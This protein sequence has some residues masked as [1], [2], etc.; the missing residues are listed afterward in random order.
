[1][2]APQDHDQALLEAGG[3]AAAVIRYKQQILGA[4]EESVRERLLAARPQRPPMIID[5]LPAF[6][7]R[8]ALSLLPG[9]G[10]S[11]ASEYSNIATQHGMERARF[12][13][14]ALRDLIHEYQ[15]LREVLADTL[16]A[17]PELAEG[18]W[19][20]IHRSIDEAMAEAASSFVRVQDEFREVFTAALSHD[21]RGPLAN[22]TNYLEL[23]RRNA[24]A[25]RAGHFATRALL[26]LR[27]IDRMI[28][29][30]LDVTQA[31]T[32]G[33]LTLRLQPCDVVVLTRDILEDLRVMHGDRFELHA[34][35]AVPA[36]LDGERL[37]QALHNLLENAVKYGREGAPISVRIDVGEGRLRLSCHNEGEPIPPEVIP[38]LFHAFRRA[39]TAI[40]GRKPGWGLGLM[41]VQSIAEAHGGG[42]EVESSRELGTT[43]T[44]DVL[45]DARELRAPA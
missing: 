39:P 12:T 3:A 15:V 34:P 35:P 33:R 19:R 10:L 31:N 29:E 8:V 21:F 43:F 7:T 36:Q 14:Y 9:T 11:F 26:N 30:L 24:D 18:D 25:S 13:H 40:S 2:A 16:G 4:F 5:T 32:S 28:G 41:L 42:V 27:M 1:V 17:A 38:D 44:I 45:L 22:A 23:L 37:K 20:V 6:L